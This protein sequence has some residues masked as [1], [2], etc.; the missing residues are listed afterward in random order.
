MRACSMK[1]YFNDASAEDL[2]CIGK[3][4]GYGKTVMRK[5]IAFSIEGNERVNN[6][7]CAGQTIPIGCRAE[8]LWFLG[9]S[10]ET[11]LKAQVLLETDCGAV[12]RFLEFPCYKGMET[13]GWVYD[14]DRILKNRKTVVYDVKNKN[15]LYAC[16]IAV[17]NQYVHSVT[18]P[19]F[20][21]MHVLAITIDE[22]RMDD[23][24]I[25]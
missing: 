2:F 13:I 14:R 25:K 3:H 12:Y 18:L 16:G 6:A 20:D 21:L 4:Y 7:F 11:A 15:F 23:Y 10:E 24:G 1:N 5:R 22:K 9:Y 17:G 8:T 19:D